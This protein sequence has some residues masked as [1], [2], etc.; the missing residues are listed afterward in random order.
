MTDLK[1]SGGQNPLS[2][3]RISAGYPASGWI[4]RDVRM[5]LV[6]VSFC[7]GRKVSCVCPKRQFP[8][9]EE[10]DENRFHPDVTENPS[11]ERVLAPV[12][13]Q[14]Y[15]GALHQVHIT[16]LQDDDVYLEQYSEGQDVGC[17]AE[18]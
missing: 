8:T 12:I 6:L 7:I 18:G 9:N 10:R 1:D 2:G 15:A 4:F 11:G 5:E 13:K 14:T 16:Y 3:G 17:Q